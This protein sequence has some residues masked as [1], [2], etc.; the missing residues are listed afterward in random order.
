MTCT[1][2]GTVIAPGKN[3]PGVP[4]FGHH[5]W[6][7]PCAESWCRAPDYIDAFAWLD[8]MMTLFDGAPMNPEHRRSVF[9]PGLFYRD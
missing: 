5:G 1:E 6:C 2:C 9:Y 8:R 3:W 7:G 4:G